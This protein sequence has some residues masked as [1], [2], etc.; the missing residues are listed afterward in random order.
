MRNS[1]VITK[2]LD[3]EDDDLG[4]EYSELRE[5]F[6]R[7]EKAYRKAEENGDKRDQDLKAEIKAITA[8]MDEIEVKGQRITT[9]KPDGDVKVERKALADFCRTGDSE[10]LAEV[11]AM[12]VPSDPDGGYLVMPTVEAGIRT[13]ARDRSPIREL[14]AAGIV[15]I[16]SDAYE[17]P[18]DPSDITGGWVGEKEARPETTSPDISATRIDVRE[19]YAAPKI[20]QKILDDASADLGA[21]LETR[22]SDKFARL[23]GLAHVSGDG[24]LQPRGF[25]SYTNSADADFTRTWGEIQYVAAGTAPADDVFADKLKETKSTLRAPYKTGA[26]WV[27]N[28]ATALRIS[29]IKDTTDRYIWRDGLQADDPDALLGSPVAFAEDMP[30]D[31]SGLVPIALANWPMAYQIVDRHGLRLVRDNLTDK[32]HVVFYAYR[33]VGGGMADFNA[34]KLVKMSA[35]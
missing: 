13:L 28:S 27:M 17:I 26:V 35:S 14:C 16:S 19:V 3:D 32:P 9:G 20:T 10:A 21:H 25:L 22:I 6:T 12:E 33:R 34:M 11:K 31:D 8:R 15:T 29:Q 4:P 18:F 30:D 5:A 24:F 2:D 1:Q 7:L 23:E